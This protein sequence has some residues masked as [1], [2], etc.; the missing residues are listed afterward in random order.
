MAR[1]ERD[2]DSLKPSARSFSK[3]RF[4]KWEITNPTSEPSHTLL[5]AGPVT[6]SFT[7]E[8]AQPVRKA[9]MASRCS[10]P[11]VSLCGRTPNNNLALE[12]RYARF[13]CLRSRLC[14]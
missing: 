2:Q 6:V 1:G 8:L 3:A 14:R 5:S 11:I 12:A 10:M 7:I 4:L 13:V 9:H